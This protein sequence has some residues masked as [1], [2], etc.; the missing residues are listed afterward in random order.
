MFVN[1]DSVVSPKQ[2]VPS[3][4][5]DKEKPLWHFSSGPTTVAC[6]KFSL[7]AATSGIFT[8]LCIPVFCSYLSFKVLLLLLQLTIK[9]SV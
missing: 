2:Y 1:F 7:M 4:E 3:L 8:S 5:K 9:F 6:V